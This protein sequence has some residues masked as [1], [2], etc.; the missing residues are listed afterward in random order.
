MPQLCWAAFHCIVLR[1][2]VSRLI[3][4]AAVRQVALASACWS[5]FFF[6]FATN[7]VCCAH[8]ARHVD[9][10]PLRPEAS[11]WLTEITVPVMLSGYLHG[12]YEQRSSAAEEWAIHRGAGTHTCSDLFLK[13]ANMGKFYDF[14]VVIS[15]FTKTMLIAKHI[16]LFWVFWDLLPKHSSHKRGSQ[17]SA[18]F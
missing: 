9:C 5:L 8:A 16:L 6:F 4:G 3:R 14:M 17:S 18:S 11:W 2:S 15:G 7:M 10:A 13:F 1:P 12:S